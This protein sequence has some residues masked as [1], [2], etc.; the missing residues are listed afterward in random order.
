MS[1]NG[2][3]VLLYDSIHDVVRA[4]KTIKARGIWCDMIPT[5]RQL[6][7]E[8]GMS[9]EVRGSDLKS[10]LLQLQDDA[11]APRIYRVV[12]GNFKPVQ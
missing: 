1:V 7:S 8:C 10:V 3:C 5:P 4:E 12:S 11:V 2:N 6:S 9:L